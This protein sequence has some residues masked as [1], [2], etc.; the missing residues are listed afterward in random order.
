[1]HV[2]MLMLAFITVNYCYSPD[3]YKT[4]YF[5]AFWLV[6]NEALDA[7]PLIFFGRNMH[8]GPNCGCCESRKPKLRLFL[9]CDTDTCCLCVQ[10]QAQGPIWSHTNTM[11]CIY[12]TDCMLCIRMGP[13]VLLWVNTGFLHL[14]SLVM[15]THSKLTHTQTRITHRKKKHVPPSKIKL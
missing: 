6:T 5:S 7:F 8:G 12:S 14:G 4:Q 3:D 13:I 15:C 9:V 11:S 10:I 2:S 1:M